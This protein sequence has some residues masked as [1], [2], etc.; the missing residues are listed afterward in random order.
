MIRRL[1]VTIVFALDMNNL[2]LAFLVLY[3]WAPLLFRRVFPGLNIWQQQQQFVQIGIVVLF[4]CSF[5]L[6][7]NR[8]K[9]K[10]IPLAMLVCYV[11]IRTAENWFTATLAKGLPF[12]SLQFLNF[13]YLIIFYVLCVQYLNKKSIAQ[14]VKW[15]SYSA[16][17]VAFFC[18]LEVFGVAQFV[19]ELPNIYHPD[20]TK[21]FVTGM[22]GNPTL[23]SGYLAMCLPLFFGKKAFNILSMSLIWIILL[24]YTGQTESVSLVGIV[25]GLVVSLYYL[26]QVSK[27]IFFC[28]ASSFLLIIPFVYGKIDTTIFAFSGRL[29]VWQKYL[30]LS[31]N[32][33]VFG[34]G[35]GSVEILSTQ[36]G[37]F[38]N[39]RWTHLHNDF[40]EFT[41]NLG[42]VGLL[43]ILYCIVEYFRVKV[44]LDKSGLVLK[45]IFV[46]FLVNCLFIFPSFLWAFT[47]LAMISY[48]SLYVYKNQEAK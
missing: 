24:F 48:A 42:L 43:L 29:A 37:K 26:S 23:I 7:Q 2:I 25:V 9:I 31:K 17:G 10:N 12:P 5:F 15:L 20:K 35:L 28:I 4:C 19:K 34:K 11:G 14:I 39:Y 46:G 18:V 44:K 41:F 8:V 32:T 16:L 36:I 22:L 1:C 6:K 3:P 21:V 27:R 45:T 13:L 33:F 47:P 38:A 30:E 40:F